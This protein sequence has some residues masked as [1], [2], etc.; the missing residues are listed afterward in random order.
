VLIEQITYVLHRGKAPALVAAYVQEGAARSRSCQLADPALQRFAQT[1]GNFLV[2]RRNNVAAGV[3]FT[4]PGEP[5]II[6]LR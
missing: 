3:L 6:R 2:R 4:G 5:E 1:Y